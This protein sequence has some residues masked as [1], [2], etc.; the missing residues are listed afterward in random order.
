MDGQIGRQVR[1]HHLAIP[2]QL[3]DERVLT[4]EGLG[5]RVAD[6]QRPHSSGSDLGVR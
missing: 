4:I 6:G 5:A 1:A 2:K 3:S